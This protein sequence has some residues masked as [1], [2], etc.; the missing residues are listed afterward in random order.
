MLALS[1]KQPKRC[2]EKLATFLFILSS[3]VS[4]T[5]QI[6]IKAGVSLAHYNVVRKDRNNPANAG[7]GVST[8]SKTGFV[9]GGYVDF[10]INQNLL[11]RTGLEVVTKGGLEQ[12]QETYNGTTYFFRQRYNFTT[13]DLP[14]TLLLKKRMAN[15]H[16]FVGGGLTPGLVIEGM[17]DKFDL[18][19]NVVAG[20]EFPFRLNAAINYNHGLLNVANNSFDYT[21]LKNRYLGFTIGY[22]FRQKNA[23]E[24][25]VL[26]KKIEEPVITNKPAKALFAELGGPGGFLSFNYDMRFSKSYKGLGIRAGAGLLFDFYNVGYSLPVAVNYLAGKRAHFLEVSAGASFVHFNGT[27]Q[28]SWFSFPEENFVSPFIWAGYRYQPDYK[29]FVFRVGFTK[30]LSEKEQDFMELPLPSL[31]F[32]YSIR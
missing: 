11:L 3:F 16:F 9:L 13:F 31:S 24:R 4:Y 29:K 10:G 6:G 23:V 25:E 1:T 2:Y 27:N 17:F 22:S 8:D 32:G 19:A 7:A 14:L 26:Q 12:K 30:F 15:G 21:N 20:Y 18:G 5:Q 28:D